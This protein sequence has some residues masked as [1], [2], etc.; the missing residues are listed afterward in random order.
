MVSAVEGITFAW[1]TFAA[2]SQVVAVRE[3]TVEVS[4]VKNFLLVEFLFA[5]AYSDNV[6]RKIFP[7]VPL[8]RFVDELVAGSVLVDSPLE[9]DRLPDVSHV[10]EHVSDF[11]DDA[12]SHN[13]KPPFLTS[14][15]QGCKICNGRALR[16]VVCFLF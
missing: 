5:V 8:N 14:K 16:F 13:I 12:V 9:V 7:A 15:A 6:E 1:K 11:V 2:V 10:V 4:N 3:L